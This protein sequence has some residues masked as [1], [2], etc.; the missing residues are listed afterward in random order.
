M[1]IAVLGA[2]GIGGYYG[3]L[4]ARGGHDVV[5]VARGAHLEA[6]QRRGLTVCT[7]AGEST[8]AVAAVGDTRSVGP[9]DLVLFCV[10][11]YDTDSAARALEPLMSRSTAVLTLQNGLDNAAA[12]AAT[13]G[14]D[15]VL[16]G[17]VYVAL[18][19]AEPGVIRHTGGD[20]KIVFGESGGAV[21]G[22]ARRIAT[23]FQL[24][25]IPHALSTDIDRVLWDKF[26]FIAGVGAVTAL[27]R[28]TIGSLLASAS[29]RA[30]L[31][32]S[33]EEIVAVGRAEGRFNQP[34]AVSTVIAQAATLPPEWRSSMARDLAD[35][36]RLEVDALSG[37]VV[38][39]SA[40]HGIST[41]VHQIISACLSLHQPRTAESPMS[42]APA[43]VGA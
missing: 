10:K 14:S 11:S 17:A 22:R 16:S 6:I 5:L 28:V 26:L 42:T 36:R 4:L 31:T 23:A 41:P 12:V 30:L 34:D 35:G 39:R 9:V 27:A 24:A 29:G 20:G 19:L 21:S 7:A 13:I 25:G 38:R 1:R 15:A 8:L 40:Y 2:G 3:A 33:C 43:A 32:A 18:Q 37:A